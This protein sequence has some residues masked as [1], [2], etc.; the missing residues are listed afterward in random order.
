MAYSRG[1]RKSG[2]TR[3]KFSRGASTYNLVARGG[4]RL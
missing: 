3:T 2:R 1:R 4:I